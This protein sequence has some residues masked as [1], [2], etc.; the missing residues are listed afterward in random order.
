M[1]RMT[2]PGAR[3]WMPPEILADP[4]PIERRKGPEPATPAQLDAIAE[5]YVAQMATR[6]IACDLPSVLQMARI[7]DAWRVAFG[8]V[9][10]C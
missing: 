9:L 5:Q 8:R 4:R 2:D 10:K 6:G 7:M 1:K 3:P